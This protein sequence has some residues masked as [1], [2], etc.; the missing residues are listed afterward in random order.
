MVSRMSSIKI[1]KISAISSAIGSRSTPAPIAK[2]FIDFI[3]PLQ[4]YLEQTL[5]YVTVLLKPEELTDR[6]TIRRKK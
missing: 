6:S 5:Q 4:F 3:N 2:G 1:S